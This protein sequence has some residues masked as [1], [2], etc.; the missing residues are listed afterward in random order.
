MD[1]FPTLAFEA[2]RALQQFKQRSPYDEPEDITD[3]HLSNIFAPM[4]AHL[5]ALTN[6]IMLG[7]RPFANWD[8][9]NPEVFLAQA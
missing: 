5:D 2:G 9:V 4:Q 7:G 6:A 3:E 8:P 1:Q